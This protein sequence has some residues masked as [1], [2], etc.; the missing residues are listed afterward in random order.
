MR[1]WRAMAALAVLAAGCAEPPPDG[2]QGYAEGEFVYVASPYAGAVERLAVAR[3]DQVRAG[4]VLFVLDHGVEQGAVDAAKAQ[5]RA[6]EAQIANLARGRR[7]PEVETAQAQ[8]ANAAA[9]LRLARLQLDQA[10]KLYAAGYVSKARLD[11]ARA[12]FDRS[13]AGVAEMRA[14][15]ATQTQTLGRPSEIAAAQA[16]L[17]AARATLDQAVVRLKQKTGVAPRDALVQ[18]TLYRLGEWVA[19]GQPVVSLLPP[20]NRKVRFFVPETVV[21]ALRPGEPVSIECD[22]CAAP[23]AATISYVSTQAEYTPPVIYSRDTRQKLVFM[24]EA[25]PAPA[26]APRLHPGQPVTVRRAQ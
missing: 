26:D 21:G 23:I 1:R 3:G 6:A 22:G 10:E 7:K 13:A 11:E 12:E 18:D 15:I 5:V 17:A 8:E 25:R 14:Q 2:W 9:A 4:E 20:E 24:I 16:E 19:A